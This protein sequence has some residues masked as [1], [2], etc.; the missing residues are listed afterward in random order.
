MDAL[1]CNWIEAAGEQGPVSTA[2]PVVAHDE[3]EHP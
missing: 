2:L 1:L 3:L